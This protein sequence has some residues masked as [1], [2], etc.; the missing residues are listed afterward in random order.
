MNMWNTAFQVLRLCTFVFNKC[1]EIII[2]TI[3]GLFVVK[4]LKGFGWNNVGPASMYRAIRSFRR[5]GFKGHQYYAAVRK[6]STI[7]QC[8][9]NDG[10]AS[11][12]VGQH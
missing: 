2:L 12:T 5:R 1:S 7:T 8:C 6:D 4:S 11:N 3:I 9:F 10:P